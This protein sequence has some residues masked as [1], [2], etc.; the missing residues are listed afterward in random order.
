VAAGNAGQ[1]RGETEEDIGFIFGRVHASGAIPARELTAE[2]EWNVVGNGRADVSENELE[3]W[4]GAQDRFGV[5]VKPPGGRWTEVVSP[6][7]FIENRRLADGSM[8]SVYNELYHPANGSNLIAVYLSP[9]LDEPLVGVSAGEWLVRLVGEEVR[10]GRYH[11]WIERDD[12]RRVGRIGAREAWLFPSFFSERSFAD[13]STISSL[14]CGPRI[15]AVANLDQGRRRIN[16]SSSQGPTRDGRQKPDVC[17]PGTD[18]VAARGFAS[19]ERW[20]A[21]TGT[22]MAS[23]FVAGVIGLMLAVNKKLTAAQIGG[24]L[25]RTADPLPGGDF[26]WRDDAGAGAIDPERCL[27]EAVT[28]DV[29]VDLTG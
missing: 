24:I 25:R 16:I 3:V 11:C 9:F 5:Q 14:A 4:Y 7:Q 22:S 28:M 1:E 23:P 19:D 6:G 18:I 29:R 13:H 26:S 12:P 15:V 17:A 10:D 2:I 27:E 21:M 8:L 20:V